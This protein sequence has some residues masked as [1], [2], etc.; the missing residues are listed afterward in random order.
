MPTSQTTKRIVVD[1][2][3]ALICLMVR[4]TVARAKMITQTVNNHDP[5]I[6]SCRK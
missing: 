1:I 3:R 4:L 2:G 5:V 6:L